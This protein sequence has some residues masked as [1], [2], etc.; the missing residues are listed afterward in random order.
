[1][2]NVTTPCVTNN[3]SNILVDKLVDNVDKQESCIYC[4][5]CGR[6]LQKSDSLKLHM[7]PYCYKQYMKEKN[8]PRKLF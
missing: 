1:M 3:L 2:A 5:R 7:G 4:I 6:K 8:S